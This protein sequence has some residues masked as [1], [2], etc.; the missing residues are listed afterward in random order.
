MKVKIIKPY[1]YSP[2]GNSVETLK[3]GD[4]DI[5][6]RWAKKAIASGHTENKSKPA[7]SNKAKKAPKN[8]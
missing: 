5:D 4:H 2:D 6:E 1:K 3:P 8:K 7:P